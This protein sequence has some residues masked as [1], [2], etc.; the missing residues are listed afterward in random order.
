MNRTIR[1][2]NGSGM[3]MSHNKAPCPNPIVTSFFALF[4]KSNG[5][6]LEV[7]SPEALHLYEYFHQVITLSCMRPASSPDAMPEQMRG[8]ALVSVA[9]AE[10]RAEASGGKADQQR[11]RREEARDQRRPAGQVGRRACLDFAILCFVDRL[12]DTLLRISLRRTIARLDH[13]R[14]VVAIPRGEFT[15]FDTARDNPAS[16]VA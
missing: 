9:A 8:G 1:M 5:L 16:F 6:I 4:Q 2:I 14:Q 3:P 11:R 12:I 10:A 13:L 15:I 7:H